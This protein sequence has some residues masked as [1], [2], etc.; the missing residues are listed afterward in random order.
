MHI[1][2]GGAAA[3]PHLGRRKYD[4]DIPVETEDL[5]K[6]QD[7]DHA[8]EDPRLLHVG[9]YALVADDAD[10]V[11]RREARHP[12]RDATAEVHE[13]AALECQHR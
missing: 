9:A 1:Y 2:R 7:Q 10:A 13:A 12:H 11:A 4:D 8:D 5:T 6:D 3:G